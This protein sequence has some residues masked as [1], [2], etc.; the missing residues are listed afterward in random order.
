MLKN[1][2]KNNYFYT[3]FDLKFYVNYVDVGVFIMCS[4]KKKPFLK[5]VKKLFKNT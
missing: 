1:S 3:F 5:L 2:R 4:F